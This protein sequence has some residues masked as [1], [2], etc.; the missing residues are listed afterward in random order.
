MAA[1]LLR[2]LVEFNPPAPTSQRFIDVP[3]EN[4]FYVFIDRLAARGITLGCNP[5]G[6][7]FCPGSPLTRDQM[8]AFLVR[9]FG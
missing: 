4:G 1:F 7:Q 5:Q 3:P 8:A 2:A 9:A 6:T